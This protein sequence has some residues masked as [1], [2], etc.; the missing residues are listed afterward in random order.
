M[1]QLKDLLVMGPSRFVGDVFANNL[2]AFRVTDNLIPIETNTYSLGSSDLKWKSLFIGTANTYGSASQPIWWNNGVPA[3]TTHALNA[4]INAGTATRLAFYDGN[5]GISPAPHV[6]YI[7][8][9][10][11]ELGTTKKTFTG[12]F[13]QGPTAG[14]AAAN[15][16]SGISNVFRY[17]DPGPQI[18]FGSDFGDANTGGTNA[19]PNEAGAII[20]SDNSTANYLDSAFY[21]VAKTGG[22]AFTEAN[23]GVVSKFFVARSGLTVG[24]NYRDTNYTLSVNG[25]GYF[26]GAISGNTIN[27]N[28]ANA[29]NAGGLSLYSTTPTNYGIAMRKPNTSHGWITEK[30]ADAS[31]AAAQGIATTDST[32]ID[33]NINFYNSGSKL[34]GFKFI[35]GG[36][37]IASL[38]GYGYLQ[39]N[40]LGLNGIDEAPNG[41][42]YWYS[43][44]YYTW[45]D[46]ISDSTAGAA[47]T[48]GTPSTT[49][50]VT[51]L[52]N[53]SLIENSAGYGWIWEATSNAVAAA[54]TT[55]P[56]A[57]M[58]LSSNT[59]R[60]RIE[61]NASTNVNQESSLIVSSALNGGNGD[62]AIELWRGDNASWQ[63]A[64]HSGRLYIR[65]NYTT[66]VQ[67]SY[68]QNALKLEYDTGNATFYGDITLDNSSGTISRVGKAAP[69]NTSNTRA[70]IRMT[71][72][73]GWSPLWA[74]KT[75]QGWW[76][77][78]H[79][80]SAGDYDHLLFGFLSDVDVQGQTNA[81]N[82]LD[83]TVRLLPTIYETNTSNKTNR[84][85]VTA[86]Y[87][88]ASAQIGSTTQPIYVDSNGEVQT[89][90][91]SLS[92][93][94]NSGAANRM[95]YYSGANEISQASSI[96]AS[97]NSMTIN[98]TSAPAK[99]SA[100][101]LKFQVN[102]SAA[103]TGD[104][105][106][107]VP[108]TTT[109][110]Q[111]SG[112]G[113]YINKD[114]KIKGTLNIEKEGTTSDDISTLISLRNYDST[115]GKTSTSQIIAHNNHGTSSALSNL[116]IHGGG[117][118]II[119]SGMSGNNLYAVKKSSW[120]GV[121]KEELFVVSDE[122]INVE[123]NANTIANRIGFQVT[124]AGHIIPIKAEAANNNAQDIG[125]SDNKWAN[126][127][128]TNFVGNAATATKFASDQSITLTG[129]TTGTASSQAG[130][131]IATT[132]K[133]LTNSGRLVSAN[134]DNS[135]ATYL[136][137]IT[138]FLA[139]SSMTEGKPP[140]DAGILNFAWDNNKWGSQLAIRMN[141]T[142]H[143]YLR[144]SNGTS[145]W[146][147]N[148]LTVL[149]SNNY[150]N[151]APT[152][153]GTGATGTWEISIT[154]SSAKL[155]TTT[156][157]SSTKPIYL[158]GGTATECSTYAGGTL[159]TL[160]GTQKDA[161]TASFYAPT[162]GGTS[163]QVLKST[164]N[165]APTWQAET[166]YTLTTTGTGN[167][168]TG[169]SLSGTTFTVTKGNAGLTGTVT[170]GQ[171]GTGLTSLTTNK[172]Y[173][174][175]ASTTLTA[176]NHSIDND[177]MAI[178]TTI[179]TGYALYVN[180]AFTA[181]TLILPT[182]ASTTNNAIWIGS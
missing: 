174:A 145:S 106:V 9:Q 175:S 170:V 94:I 37:T 45:V 109:T 163:G 15:L 161:S 50:E 56:T 157:G 3:A 38:N 179:Q 143:V 158:N 116:V 30:Q 34:R 69:W 75:Y 14:N 29:S 78:G 77:M 13:I 144:G 54:D 26:S 53:R 130:W 36:L 73:D 105:I 8:E 142:P 168:V 46:Y 60:L 79:Y 125:T 123:A 114:T 162:D 22:S 118:L 152:K 165:S 47:P 141:S 49:N 12:L 120:F 169:V 107:G 66:A 70:M 10:T 19:G 101:T 40:R 67:T 52:A 51:A 111:A 57:R 87:A 39:V 113:C 2:Q 102:G 154:G 42:L 108:A 137:K 18:R 93:K 28:V 80:N 136:N 5:G 97:T 147:T 180:G 1:A 6:Q 173:Y 35:H 124:T 166:T 172:I 129:D 21:F 146:D 27:A 135:D 150:N 98:G 159:V 155:G 151:Y 62:V 76:T 127:Y 117:N 121:A 84:A 156:V 23:V 88:S 24:Q 138:Y 140:L 103:V 148:W 128:A 43:P 25:T 89:T 164:G 64:N 181:T 149:D 48:G 74:M 63:I 72:A 65:N 61:A 7:P 153:T 126:V 83:Y 112:S 58:S 11:A 100:R 95:A 91:Y 59:G 119:G 71:T 182:S 134:V 122:V 115:T 55:K 41:R 82:H 104:F 96:Y 139:T 160:N 133:K 132:T 44:S 68:T 131:S 171:G 31:I 176:S 85:F 32:G 167:A 177:Q 99:I 90:S 17:G 16:G 4:T 110:E 92:A 81:K 20:W 178:N 86:E 33:W